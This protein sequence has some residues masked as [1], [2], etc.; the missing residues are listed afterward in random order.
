MAP[1]GD[2]VPASKRVSE[3]IVATEHRTSGKWP[4]EP[5][6]SEGW[7]EAELVAQVLA[8]QTRFSEPRFQP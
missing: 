7:L 5:M 2:E 4:Q 8:Q 3:W 6:R 1:L